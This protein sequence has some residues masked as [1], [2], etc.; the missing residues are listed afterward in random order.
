[1]T[2]EKKPFNFA[3]SLSGPA[4]APAPTSDPHQDWWD[5]IAAMVSGDTIDIECS[6]EKSSDI[7]NKYLS[8]RQGGSLRIRYNVDTQ[9]LTVRK[10]K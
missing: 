4:P 1:M 2:E 5:K 3:T 6:L 8:Q 10:C 7:F 9:I